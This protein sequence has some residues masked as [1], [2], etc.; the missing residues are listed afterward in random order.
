MAAMAA[1]PCMGRMDT[2]HSWGACTMPCV[3]LLGGS[4]CSLGMSSNDGQ[5]VSGAPPMHPHRAAAP[6]P[7]SG[8]AAACCFPPH[9]GAGAD[10]RLPLLL[11]PN[12][13][14]KAYRYLIAPL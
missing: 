5:G 7:T 12:A 6:D 4:M 2:I 9:G 14:E 10:R 1:G 3:M 8:S 13:R 11:P